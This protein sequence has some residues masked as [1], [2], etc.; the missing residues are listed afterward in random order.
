MNATSTH[1]LTPEVIH[2]ELQLH[3]LIGEPAPLTCAKISNR[4]NSQTRLFIER[5][6]SICIATP[7]RISRS[8]WAFWSISTR[9]ARS[10][11]KHF[12]AHVCGIQGCMWIPRRCLPVEKSIAPSKA[13]SLMRNSTTR[14]AASATAAVSDSI[15]PRLRILC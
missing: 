5:S 2:T 11:Q 4:L 15:D 10:V 7:S 9:P 3:T 6:S 13:S 1:P 12:Y 8:Y 14:N